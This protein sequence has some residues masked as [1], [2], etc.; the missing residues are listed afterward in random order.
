MASAAARWPPSHR[1]S[2]SA[3][4]RIFPTLVHRCTG[5]GFGLL[6]GPM[7]Q[8]GPRA[9]RTDTASHEFVSVRRHAALAPSLAG[10]R[11]V[12]GRHRRPEIGRT[13]GLHPR[14]AAPKRGILRAPK[15]SAR[16]RR[17][18]WYIARKHS[19]TPIRNRRRTSSRSAFLAMPSIAFKRTIDPW[20]GRYVS[21]LSGCRNPA[22]RGG[23]RASSTWTRGRSKPCNR[24]RRRTLHDPH[25]A[26]G[27]SKRSGNSLTR[28]C[29]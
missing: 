17:F 7:R 23:G 12:R 10:D 28:C 24:E 27:A 2:S 11:D 26:R 9:G 16:A 3:P 20:P 4:V 18:R 22:R 19:L 25:A 8:E 13:V 29:A 14:D 6:S 15:K 1:E 21:T 5:V